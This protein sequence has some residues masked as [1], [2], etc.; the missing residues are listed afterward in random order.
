MALIFEALACVLMQAPLVYA[1]IALISLQAC[2]FK[3][4]RALNLV[5]PDPFMAFQI[6]IL[7]P[8]WEYSGGSSLLSFD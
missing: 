4:N 7:G 3:P 1:T 6:S 5:Q 2:P 8:F